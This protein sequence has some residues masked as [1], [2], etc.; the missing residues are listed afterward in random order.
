[1]PPFP[2][3]EL[4]QVETKLF[5]EGVFRRYGYDFRQYAPASMK[6]RIH[7]CLQREELKTVSALQ[8][9][10]LHDPVCLERFLL[11][12]TVNTTGMFRDPRFYI[13]FREIVTPLLRQYSGARIWHAGCSTGEEVY[14]MA[15]LLREE[16]VYDQCQLYATDLSEAALGRA[17]EGV[18]SLSQMRGYSE[19]YLSAG[20]KGSLAEYYTAAYGKAILHATLRRN[21]VFAQHNLTTDGSFNEFQVIL[22]RNVMIYFDQSLQARVSRLFYDSLFPSGLLALGI[23]EVLHSAPEGVHFEVL[24]NASRIYRKVG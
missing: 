4:E 12:V 23:R 3:L 22:C 13:A 8:D 10:I 17:E 14:S 21:V 7:L 9:R 16:G 20:G 18:Y 1:M 11:T 15:I 2:P 19:N 6:R 24:D 5:L